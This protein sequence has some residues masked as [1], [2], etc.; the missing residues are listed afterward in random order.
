MSTLLPEQEARNKIIELL[1]ESS[2]KTAKEV[3]TILHNYS[4]KSITSDKA[5]QLGICDGIVDINS[6]IKESING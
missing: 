5:I 4:D 6:L 1:A 3:Q 2:E